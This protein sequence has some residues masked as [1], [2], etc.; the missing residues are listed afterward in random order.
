MTFDYSTM[1][2]NDITVVLGYFNNNGTNRYTKFDVIS[3]SVE[4]SI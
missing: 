2:N 3:L 1:S 4:K